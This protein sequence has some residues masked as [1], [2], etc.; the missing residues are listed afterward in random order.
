VEGE[1]NAVV[2]DGEAATVAGLRFWGIGDPRYTPDKS[3]P[4]GGE[5]E[6]DVAEA[7]A[8]RVADV[9]VEDE[10]PP[11]D[12]VLIHDP[13][14][15]ADLGG[16]APLVLAGHGHQ[17]RS[18]AIDPREPD[19]DTDGDRADDD[20]STTTTEGSSTTGDGQAAADETLLL[21]EGSTG[22]AG[23]R[24]L[25]G[26]EPEP[27]TASVLYFDPASRQLLAYDRITVAGLGETGA[28]IERHV[29]GAGDGGQGGDGDD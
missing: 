14:A 29:I 9:L 4:V 26:E 21:V 16:L 15:A 2:L 20:A 8:P 27:L 28:T 6:M 23:L 18:S 19:E 1:P 17:A 11:V 5:S 25:Q 22:G 12:V 7:Y 13:R 3:H 24:G 10:P